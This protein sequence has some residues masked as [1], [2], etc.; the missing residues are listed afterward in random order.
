MLCF[1]LIGYTF[2]SSLFALWVARLVHLDLAG[3]FIRDQ[4]HDLSYC[5]LKFA[6]IPPLACV[7][8][9]AV[10]GSS[11]PEF[12]A[13]LMFIMRH[14]PLIILA[15]FVFLIL[16]D[17][18]IVL[19]FGKTPQA[20]FYMFGV[21]EQTFELGHAGLGLVMIFI[22]LHVLLPFAGTIEDAI[23]SVKDCRI[24]GSRSSI[25]PPIP[26]CSSNVKPEIM[27]LIAKSALSLTGRQI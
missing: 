17:V 18:R 2:L 22:I 21:R 9:V 16:A 25:A 11:L 1:P 23:I 4:F 19:R 10:R 26:F 24:C 13:Q 27:L 20:A 12:E 6:V 3:K 15:G 8:Y 14:V 7:L 5:S